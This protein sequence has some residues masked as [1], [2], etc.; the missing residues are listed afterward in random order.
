MNKKILEKQIL[1]TKAKYNITD[2][3]VCNILQNDSE[4]KMHTYID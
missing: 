1:K 2:H 3:N 4:K